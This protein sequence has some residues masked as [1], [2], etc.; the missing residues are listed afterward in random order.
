ML[1]FLQRQRRVMIAGGAGTAKT[2]IAKEKA[3]RLAGEGMR[4]L[5]LCYNRGLADHLREQCAEIEG[6]DV[7]SFHQV[8]DL[9]NRRVLAKTGT[10]LLAEARRDYPGAD[11]YNELMPIAL[12]N[13]VD[14]N[15]GIYDAIIVDE[16]QD[17]ADDFWLPVEMLLTDPEA[18]LLYVFLDENQDIYRRSASIPVPGEPLVLDRNCRNTAA[19]HDAAYRYYRGGSVQQPEIAGSPVEILTAPT[20]EL[21]ARQI[22][23]LVTRLTQTERIAAHDIAV[24]LCSASN[25]ETCEKFLRQ[26]NMPKSIRLGRIEDYGP[27]SLT[28]DIVARFKGLERAVTIVWEFGDC[29]PERD[30]E[31]LYVG[32]SRA[33][34]LLYACGTKEACAAKFE[35]V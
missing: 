32:L 29:D 11:L 31:T 14:R 2:L 7:A 23:Q 18:A 6:L 30:R 3:I 8:C 1:D 26:C 25:R 4:A 19:I 24:L 27:N 21:Q 16:A 20:L 35:R 34:S 12:S 22:C 17:F 33:K 9:W 13:A 28:V 15:G 5:L 10:D